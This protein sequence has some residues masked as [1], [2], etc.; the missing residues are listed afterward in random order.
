MNADDPFD[1]A[2]FIKAQDPVFEIVLE[3]LRM[4]RKSSHWMWFIFPQLRGLGRSPM[5]RFYGIASLDEARAYLAHTVLADRLHRV[6]EMMLRLHGVSARD[7]LGSPDD[8]KFHS[9]MTLF[10]A[11]DGRDDPVFRQALKQY[12]NDRPDEHTRAML[13]R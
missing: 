7:V 11:A 2:R 3:E 6:T 1:L 12:F 4:G 13:G 5:A 10:H 8:L 9:S